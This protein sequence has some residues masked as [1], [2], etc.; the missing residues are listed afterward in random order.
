LEVLTRGGSNPAAF[1]DYSN[2][3]IGQGITLTNSDIDDAE[4]GVDF[5][6]NL[7]GILQN[8]NFDDPLVYAVRTSGLNDLT[9]D[10]LNVVDAAA[11]TNNNFGFYTETVSSGAQSVT[12]SNFNGVGTAIYLTNDVDT[13]IS[14]TAIINGDTG[15]EIGSS[16][17]AD[18]IFDTVTLTNNNLGIAAGGIGT[19]KMNDVDVTS[20][21]NDLNI[22]DGNTI[23]F[24]DGTI[25]ENKVTFSSSSI[26]TLD[27]DRSFVAVVTA[28]GNPIADASVGFSSRAIGESSTGYT[29][30]NGVTSG[31]K[32]SV[33]DLDANGP[34]DY[35]ADL[36]SYSLS[37]IAEVAY[38]WTSETVNDGDF[39]YIQLVYLDIDP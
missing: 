38:S 15:I 17:S 21:G 6:G 5:K 12:N 9:L 8:V 39:R 11:G 37:T 31:L 16:S 26:G 35:T 28:D 20:F 27:R 33:Y 10:G 19:I 22:T 30:S 3:I 18:H 4:I 13:T 25:D 36:N 32:F 29:D 24:L 23:S 34:T 14:N 7:I 2:E 1:G